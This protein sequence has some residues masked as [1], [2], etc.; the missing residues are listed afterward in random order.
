[1]IINAGIEIPISLNHSL[2]IDYSY[3]STISKLEFTSGGAHEI[4]LIYNVLL[5][6]KKGVCYTEWW[7]KKK[8]EVPEL[9]K[10]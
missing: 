2:L 9:K 1:V 10:K 5:P 3:D 4:T 7:K 6:Q 8:F